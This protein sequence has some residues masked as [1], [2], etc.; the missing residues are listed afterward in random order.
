MIPTVLIFS[1]NFAEAGW[2]VIFWFITFFISFDMLLASQYTQ[3]KLVFFMSNPTMHSFPCGIPGQYTQHETTAVSKLMTDAKSTWKRLSFEVL[4]LLSGFH[5]DRRKAT[6]SA[7]ISKSVIC[8][9]VL[10]WKVKIYRLRNAKIDADGWTRAALMYKM[11]LVGAPASIRTLAP[12]IAKH[13][14]RREM[15]APRISLRV[16]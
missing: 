8:A 13:R 12:L 7:H 4:F 9:R 1:R 15:F 3:K 16:W 10:D 5:V 11:M 6:T 2:K 14:G